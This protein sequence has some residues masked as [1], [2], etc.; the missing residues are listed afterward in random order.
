MNLYLGRIGDSIL[1]HPDW[2][3]KVAYVTVTHNADPEASVT[4]QEG[5]TSAALPPVRPAKEPPK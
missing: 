2:R 1:G 5:A 4:R 3:G